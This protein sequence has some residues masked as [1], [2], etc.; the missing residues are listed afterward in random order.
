MEWDLYTLNFYAIQS[1][2]IRNI[3]IYINIYKQ[4]LM[5]QRFNENFLMN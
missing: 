4:R 1:Q 3:Y 2:I 5:S